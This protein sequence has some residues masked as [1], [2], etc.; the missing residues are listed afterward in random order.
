MEKNAADRSG[1]R[2]SCRQRRAAP[3]EKKSVVRRSEQKV[4]KVVQSRVEQAV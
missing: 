1:A 4:K 3:K 2:T